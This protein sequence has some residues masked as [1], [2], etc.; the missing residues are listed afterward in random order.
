MVYYLGRFNPE[1]ISARR[2]H[3][4]YF[5]TRC[6]LNSY[7]HHQPILHDFL[8]LDDLAFVMSR[9]RFITLFPINK[10]KK[11][12]NKF[13]FTFNNDNHEDTIMIQQE[14]DSECQNIMRLA[15]LYTNLNEKLTGLCQDEMG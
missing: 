12:S 8:R 3:L 15:G 13:I 7:L 4:Q 11:W 5:L 9:H 10:W 6:S 14:M 1:V 2:H